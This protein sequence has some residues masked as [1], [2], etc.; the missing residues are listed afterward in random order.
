VAKLLE[1]DPDVLSLFAWDP[2]AG[3]PPRHVRVELYGYRFAKPGAPVWWERTRL[4]SWLPPLS[5]DD[6]RHP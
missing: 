5:L 6:L 1:G 3:V 2:F 4:G